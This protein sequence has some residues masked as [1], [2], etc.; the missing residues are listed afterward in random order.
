MT[1]EQAL[2]KLNKA[3]AEVSKLQDDEF[4]LSVEI[5]KVPKCPK[6]GALEGKG[7][8]VGS[9]CGYSFTSC[10]CGHSRDYF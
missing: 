10:K 7:Y 1:R 2:N 4:H 9:A 3:I 5:R 6:C 8:T